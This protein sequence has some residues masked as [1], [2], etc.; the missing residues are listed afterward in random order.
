MPSGGRDD[1]TGYTLHEW[2]GMHLTPQPTPVGYYPCGGGPFYT[3]ILTDGTW[4]IPGMAA[5][6][7]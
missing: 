6:T 1:S 5:L 7:F 3:A 2:D 4:L